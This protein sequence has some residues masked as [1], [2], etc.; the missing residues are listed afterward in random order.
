MEEKGIQYFYRI[1]SSVPSQICIDAKLFGEILFNIVKNAVQFNKKDGSIFVTLSS[2]QKTKKL[3]VEVKDTG[4]GIDFFK[5]KRIYRNRIAALREKN[6]MRPMF[7]GVGIG[8]TNSEILCLHLGG[9]V[10]IQSQLNMGTIV[11]FSILYDTPP[12]IKGKNN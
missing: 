10:T 9:N 4:F 1:N 11:T 6:E 7:I 5:Q 3:T 2:D 12:K 8:L